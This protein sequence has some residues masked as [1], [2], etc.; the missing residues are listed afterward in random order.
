MSREH[1]ILTRCFPLTIDHT[2][3]ERIEAASR[4][5]GTS[6]RQFAIKAL[7]GACKAVEAAYFI[8]SPQKAE[9]AP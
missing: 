1:P 9:P 7:D 2:L 5:T 4:V 8:E 6:Q 3:K